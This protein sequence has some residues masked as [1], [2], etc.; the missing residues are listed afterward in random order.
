MQE[1]YRT[2]TEERTQKKIEKR[3]H[4]TMDESVGQLHDLQL[5][6]NK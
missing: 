1:Q 4:F 2:H 5:I 6:E 3:I